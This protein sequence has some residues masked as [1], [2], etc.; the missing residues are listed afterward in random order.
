MNN[1][2]DPTTPDL[3]PNPILPDPHGNPP[4][5]A[6]GSPHPASSRFPAGTNGQAHRALPSSARGGRGWVKY[7]IGLGG[8]V[9]LGGGIF[10]FVA[11]RPAAARP[12]VLT[13]TV[14]KENLIVTV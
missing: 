12:D 1:Y 13:H 8:L 11:T 3:A 14:K 7:L 4:V 10:A 9:L 2:P 5:L 6:N